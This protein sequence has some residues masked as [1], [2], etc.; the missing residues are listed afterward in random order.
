M[1]QTAKS[2]EAE[3]ALVRSQLVAVGADIRHH[4]DPAVIVDAAKT[5]FRRR[6]EGAPSFLKEN[7]TPIGTVMLGGAFGAVLTGL[8]SQSRRSPSEGSKLTN[9]ASSVESVAHPS[10]RLQ[11]NAALLSSV[12]VGL[13]YV[14]GM[15]VP[16][17]STEDRLLGQPKAA[18]SQHLDEFLKEHTRG[19]KMAAANVFGLSRLSAAT[20]VG[21][22]MLAEAL[23]HPGESQDRIPCEKG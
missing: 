1:K 3:A 12:G 17:S 13:G 8:F 20:L 14:A 23:G 2:I 10:V 16:A 18:L 5:S 6:A 7:A 11:A 15:F 21:L 9:T 4:A 22:A 19:M